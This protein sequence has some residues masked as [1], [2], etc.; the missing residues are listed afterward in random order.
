MGVLI[1]KFESLQS[2]SI[3]LSNEFILVILE[4]CELFNEEHLKRIDFVEYF[5]QWAKSAIKSQYK[6]QSISGLR[7]QYQDAVEFTQHCDLHRSALHPSERVDFVVHDPAP[8]QGS[9][10]FQLEQKRVPGFDRVVDTRNRRLS[11]HGQDIGVRV[12]VMVNNDMTWHVV[13]L[14][15]QQRNS[16]DNTA[17]DRTPNS[18][19]SASTAVSSNGHSSSSSNAT[20]LSGLQQQYN[21]PFNMFSDLTE[22]ID[23]LGEYLG[24]KVKDVKAAARISGGS[25]RKAA[26]SGDGDS[27]SS[28]RGSTKRRR[29]QVIN[30]QGSIATVTV[31]DAD[32]VI[33]GADA[34]TVTGA[35]SVIID[36]AASQTGRVRKSASLLLPT[37]SRSPA[38][39]VSEA[40]DALDLTTASEVRIIEYLRYALDA[41]KLYPPHESTF[42]RAVLDCS[43]HLCFEGTCKDSL[44]VHAQCLIPKNKVFLLLGK[45]VDCHIDTNTTFVINLEDGKSVVLDEDS[46]H[47]WL[48]RIQVV[49]DPRLANLIMNGEVGFMRATRDIYPRELLLVYISSEQQLDFCRYASE[50][51]ANWCSLVEL[52]EL[53]KTVCASYFS[54][55]WAPASVDAFK[56]ALADLLNSY[57]RDWYSVCDFLESGDVGP[58]HPLLMNPDN[59][60][61]AEDV[62]QHLVSRLKSEFVFGVDDNKMNVAQLTRYLEDSPET[63]DGGVSGKTL[64]HHLTPA[65]CKRLVTKIMSLGVVNKNLSPVFLNELEPHAEGDA[66]ARQIAQDL[67]QDCQVIDTAVDTL[68]QAISDVIKGWLHASATSVI[69]DEV[70]KLISKALHAIL[71]PVCVDYLASLLPRIKAG[72]VL[73]CCVNALL[74]NLKR[75]HAVMPFNRQMC[76][77]TVGFPMLVL[78]FKSVRRFFSGDEATKLHVGAL[79]TRVESFVQKGH[80]ILKHPAA[81]SALFLDHRYNA[82]YLDKDADSDKPPHHDDD[83]DSDVDMDQ[84]AWGQGDDEAEDMFGPPTRKQPVFSGAGI[85]GGAVR[86]AGAV[87]PSDVSL[88]DNLAEVVSPETDEASVVSALHPTSPVNGAAEVTVEEEEEEEEEEKEDGEVSESEDDSDD[89]IDEAFVPGGQ[90]CKKGQTTAVSETMEKRY[91][92]RSCAKK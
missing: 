27:N 66:K 59:I 35:D 76:I 81:D 85:A 18:T 84:L 43:E 57:N 82:Q 29:T 34:A 37:A 64:E 48:Y 2:R 79:T 10:E 92:T 5:K 33:S 31:T 68:T 83:A 1:G 61:T 36:A 49:S 53:L 40:K 38:V 63:E 14:R 69:Y 28:Q 87:D 41:N 23:H 90:K 17:M 30:E 78:N 25:K 32:S 73:N 62:Q 12:Q 24:H 56:S 70:N 45:V 55:K 89:S 91:G 21:G 52:V 60:E 80:A 11:R 75:D 9:E 16:L 3:A 4:F 44:R 72:H 42:K 77:D 50:D 19:T 7:R 6:Y 15:R 74:G 39:I 13:S 51:E 20:S 46:P 47:S 71:T 67:L 88:L 86:S 58:L 54:S 26:A 65:V 22:Q 8:M